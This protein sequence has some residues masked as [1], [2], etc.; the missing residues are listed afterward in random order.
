MAAGSY[1]LARSD[2]ISIPRGILTAP[3]SK[4]HPMTQK[5][6]PSSRLLAFGRLVAS[7]RNP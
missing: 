4:A 3:T 2:S 1:K 5:Q 6:L 7:R